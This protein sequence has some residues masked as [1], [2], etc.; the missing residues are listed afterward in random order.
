MPIT[1]IYRFE[2]GITITF[3]R[4]HSMVRLETGEA[5]WESIRRIYAGYAYGKL[6]SIEFS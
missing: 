1:K 6:I 2:D 4:Y 3:A 5:F